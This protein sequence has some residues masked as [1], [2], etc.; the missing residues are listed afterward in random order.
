MENEE[1]NAINACDSTILG[2]SGA[3]SAG[4]FVMYRVQGRERR[5]DRREHRDWLLDAA[6]RWVSDMPIRMR[7]VQ[8]IGES[9][10][11]QVYQLPSSVTYY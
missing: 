8:A 5:V 9:A 2:L 11:A 3:G 10:G 1:K 7:H 6:T 4:K